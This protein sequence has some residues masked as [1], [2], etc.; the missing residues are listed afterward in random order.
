M[1]FVLEPLTRPRIKLRRCSVHGSASVV[2]AQ[3]LRIVSRCEGLSSPDVPWPLFS[4]LLGLIR[5]F[6]QDEWRDSAAFPTPSPPA[7][8]PLPASLA[9]LLPSLPLLHLL[10]VVSLRLLL[11]VP[12]SF[13]APST[14]A[15]IYSSSSSL[16]RRGAAGTSRDDACIRAGGRER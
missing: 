6:L 1:V 14:S 16:L 4:A 13:A 15:S 3:V 9:V 7:S 10:R 2:C 5:R 11:S 8:P 12:L